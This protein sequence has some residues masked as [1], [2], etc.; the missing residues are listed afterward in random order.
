MGYHDDTEELILH[1]TEKLKEHL[2]YDVEQNRT[3]IK[4]GLMLFRQGSVYGVSLEGDTIYGRVQDVIP[5]QCEINLNF[6]HTS[7]CTCPAHD[8]CRH[9][10][11]VFFK[12]Y[13]S[14]GRI[15]ALLD[16]WK[17]NQSKTDI[18]STSV[19]RAS[20]LIKPYEED[21][22]SS[23]LSFFK[24]EYNQFKQQRNELDFYFISSIYHQFFQTL[25][26][27]GPKGKE[28]KSLYTIHAAMFSLKQMVQI[29]DNFTHLSRYQF[30]ANITPYVHNLVDAIIDQAYELHIVSLPFSMDNLLEDSISEIRESLLMEGAFTYE[31]FQLFRVLWTTIFH[32]NKWV[33]DE[34]HYLSQMREL[35]N[36]LTNNEFLALSHLAFVKKRDAEALSFFEE[37]DINLVT[38]TF[39]WIKY[40]TEAKDWKRAKLWVEY[41]LKHIQS[42]VFESETFDN[43]RYLT[44]TYLKEISKYGSN[45]DENAYVEALRKLI[46]YSYVE[47]GYYLINSKDYHSWIELQ[48]YL[49]YDVSDCDKDILKEIEADDLSVLLPFYHQAVRKALAEKNRQSYKRAVRYLKKLKTTYRKLNKEET[50]TTYIHKIAQANRRLR[51]FQEELIRAKLIT[52]NN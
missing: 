36:R 49:G 34:F 47:Y 7:T 29:S 46:P 13:S 35:K 25:L 3:I 30:D 33:D 20:Q 18:L 11:A 4:K 14:V 8:F 16:E 44:R 39:W 52:I 50:W 23:W 2:S 9:R 24:R 19:I 1:Y 12:V 31:R 22:L 43:R 10:M 41:S 26:R 40:L 15:G 5:V 37:T 45:Y 6:I 38:Y 27:K 32:R 17:S 28:M 48:M 21:S 42:F 51:A